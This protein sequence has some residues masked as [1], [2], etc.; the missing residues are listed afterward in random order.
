MERVMCDLTIDYFNGQ[1]TTEEQEAFERHL[2]SCADCQQELA[3]WQ[4]LSEDLP[5]VSEL[6]EPPVGMKERVLGSILGEDSPAQPVVS[7]TPVIPMESKKPRK[8]SASKWLPLVAAALVLS[9]VGNAYLGW[10]V[11]DQQQT[12]VTQS[13][14]VDQL[15]A[16]VNLQPLEGDS[17][18]TASIVRNGDTIQVVV[19]AS[20]LPELSNE[21]VYQVWLID[22]EGPDRAG[23][24]TST[25]T[26]GAVVYTLPAGQD[27][28][29]DQIAVSHE[30]NKDSETPLGQVLMAS[31][32]SAPETE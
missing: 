12:L 4:A 1:L 17:T 23:T 22:E 2:E 10:M 13:E 27:F 18:G 7:P 31:A 9:L 6:V 30:P 3:E 29:W 21:E 5:Y 24:F 19:Q 15:V 32:I 20:S 8:R 16:L 28:S 25:G 26:D 14:T 11:Q